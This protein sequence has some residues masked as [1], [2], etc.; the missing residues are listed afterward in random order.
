VLP[1]RWRVF[2]QAIDQLENEDGSALKHPYSPALIG[3]GRNYQTELSECPGIG[4]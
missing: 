3:R 4:A 2:V 1:I